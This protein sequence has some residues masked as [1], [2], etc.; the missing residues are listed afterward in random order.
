MPSA[1]DKDFPIT[2]QALPY[3]F[4]AYR[5]PLTYCASYLFNIKVILGIFP[6]VT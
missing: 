5:A 2:T 6:S 1:E 3:I 4:P